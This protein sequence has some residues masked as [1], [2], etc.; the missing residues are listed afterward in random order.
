MKR[1]EKRHSPSSGNELTLAEVDSPEPAADEILVRIK[2]SSLN[3]HDFLVARGL[4]PVAEGRVLMSDGVGEVVQ[5][6]CDVEEFQPGQ[7]VM[8]TFFPDWLDGPPS[9]ERTARMRG[10]Q[11]DGFASEYVALPASSFTLAPSHLSDIEAAT[12]PCAALTAWRA[13]FVEGQIKPGDTVLT[14]G[15]GGVSI[16]ALQFAK[17]VGATVIATSSSEQKLDR[18]RQLGAD[19]TINYRENPDWGT[20]VRELTGGIGVDHIIEVVAGDL[21][22]TIQALRA[23]GNIYMI[24]ALSL[25]PI[26]FRPEAFILQNMHILGL[27]VGSRRHQQEMVRAIEANGLKPVIDQCFSFEEASQAFMHQESNAHFGKIC[28]SW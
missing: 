18:L 14:Q 24:G 3:F 10:D 22:N 5:V 27:T 21:T 9:A 13:L 2:A 8:G 1:L 16:F 11:V 19:Y 28:L 25:A 15:T 6:G 23:G 17:M 12:L 26:Q 7:R 4:I 20:T